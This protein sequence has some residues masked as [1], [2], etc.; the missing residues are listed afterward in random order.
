MTSARLFPLSG[1]AFVAL[2]VTSLAV[3][4]G[5]PDSGAP[6]DEVGSFYDDGLARQFASTFVLAASALF[7]VLFGVGLSN[8]LSLESR[9]TAWGHVV[10]A[11]AILVAGS[12]LV[13]AFVHMALVDGGDQSI[14]PTALQALNSLD[15]N[16]WIAFTTG[17]GV[18]MLGAAG[19][20]LSS[21]AWRWLGWTALVLGVALF[22]PFADFIAMLVSAIWIVVT[23]VTISRGAGRASW[24]TP[25]E[26]E[27]AVPSSL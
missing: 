4:G 3:G 26:G 21:G 5:T 25:L 16:T 10:Q 14:S 11:G 18:L 1:I 20:M 22:V 23:G 27:N 7:A 6:V 17:L 13:S 19:G 12:V 9:T 24:E 15:G 8:S 2:I